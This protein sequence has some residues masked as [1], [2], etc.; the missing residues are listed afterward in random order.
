MQISQMLRKLLQPRRNKD[1]IIFI[2]FFVLATI[3]W[4]GHAMQSVRNTRVQ[5]D[6]RYIGKPAYIGLGEE[7]LPDHVMIDVRDAGHRLVDYHREPLQITIDLHQYVHGDSGMIQ[8]PSTALRGS[9]KAALQAN[10]NLLNTYP[11]EIRCSYFR[12]HEKTVKLVFGGEIQLADGYQLIGKPRLQKQQITI[13]GKQEMLK[14]IDSLLTKPQTISNLNDTLRRYIAVDLPK[15]V[16]AEA[17]SVLLEVYTEQFEEKR[18][19]VPIVACCVPPH[20]HARLFPATAE[21]KVRIGMRYASELKASDLC[22][23]CSIPMMPK[24]KLDLELD[25][26]ANPHITFG[27]V[28]PSEV[29]YLVE[30]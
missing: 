20:S 26:S 27:W 8:I 13:Y 4:Y 15:G 17:D 18:F 30:E 2:L 5:V 22:V 3:I 19:E 14:Q 24:K 16:R 7:G 25:Y 6:I 28:Y 10:S 29:E 21:V 11:E 1:I 23:T 12:E 9:I